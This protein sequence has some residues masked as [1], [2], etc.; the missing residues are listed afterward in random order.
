M[1]K[2]LYFKKISLKNKFLS[3]ILF[4]SISL[5]VISFI[6]AQSYQN[7]FDSTINKLKNE[8]FDSIALILN[9]DRDMY[10]SMQYLQYISFNDIKGTD[11]D[12]SLSEFLENASQSIE[13][14]EK[15]KENNITNTAFL[16]KN[17]E[18]KNISVYFDDFI[19]EYN[20]WIENATN[21]LN[22]GNYS[23]SS[24]K[25]LSTEFENIRGN[26][27][28]L[29]E[30]IELQTELQKNSAISSMSQL[31]TIILILQIIVILV[32]ITLIILIFGNFKKIIKELS[33]ISSK[34]SN[35]EKSIDIIVPK[36]KEFS[37]IYESFKTIASKAGYFKQ[38]LD[39]IPMPLCVVDLNLNWT[40]LND[41]YLKLMNSTENKLIGQHCQTSQGKNYTTENCAVE[42]Y[43]RNKAIPNQILKDKIFDV[44]CSEIKSDEGKVIAYTEILNDITA[45]IHQNNY[46]S[47]EMAKFKENLGNIAN[48]NFNYHYQVKLPDQYSNEEYK[49]FYELN[50]NLTESLLYVKKITEDISNILN[51]ISKSNL[52]LNV[53]SEYKG[54]FNILKEALNNIINNF[55]IIL[56]DMDSSSNQFI[57]SARQL[58]QS[59][60]QLS[61]GALDQSNSIETLKVSMST[62]QEET[63]KNSDNA[64]SAK[65]LSENA[66]RN[67][68]LGNTK[69]NDMLESMDA[70]NDSSANIS[71]IIKV[72]DEIAFQTNILSLNAAVE[73]ARAGQ[74]GKG[75]AVVAEEVRNLA[76]RSADAAS[77]TTELIENTISKVSKGSKIA[78]ETAFA[79]KNI[80]ESVEKTADIVES[81]AISSNEQTDNILNINSSVKNIL[82]VTQ[83]N[84][85]TAE[86]NAAASQELLSQ[87]ELLKEKVS[88]F[89]LKNTSP[90][91]NNI[92]VENRRNLH[93]LIEK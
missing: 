51:E 85:A 70:I 11:F 72:I 62:I 8:Y 90:A 82:Q 59:S 14:V 93:Y 80:V 17:V 22:S 55:N 1:L 5:L 7:K 63:K 81:I 21:Y 33:I 79:L 42:C 88:Q 6:S 16:N 12:E 25:E 19:N 24:Y 68:L 64:N 36:D 75:F 50:Q 44:T 43:K 37:S 76:N 91:N 40:L 83:T 29:G 47:K 74:H 13:R 77:E 48:G 41:S 78:N 32:S 87:S 65:N 15:A 60:Q 3:V 31:K 27:D 38:I 39:N 53:E 66:K 30:E 57:S 61:Q 10:Q 49:V 73:A 71:K 45:S 9:S 52:N 20:V 56:S 34:I 89:N 46:K 84:S 18:G 2:N 23:L 35:N 69:M 67:A 58:S 4:I 92:T 26:L 54:D 86:E 28:L